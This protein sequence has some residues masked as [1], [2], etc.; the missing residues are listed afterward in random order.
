[1][2]AGSVVVSFSNA[3][4]PLRLTSSNDGRWSDTWSPV[5]STSSAVLTANAQTTSPV[6]SG[7]ISIG[8]GIQDNPDPPVFTV[9]GM[10]NAANS[11]PGAPLAP[12]SLISIYGLKL[13][14]SPAAAPQLPLE[15]ALQ[16]VE[17]VAAARN[18]PLHYTTSEQ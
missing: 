11:S 16:G 1:M 5:H 14:D 6:L 18:L 12:G 10:I 2:T 15:G 4:S 17:V 13:A 3:D 9:E 7:T 8:G